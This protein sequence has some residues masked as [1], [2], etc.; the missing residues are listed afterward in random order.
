MTFQADPQHSGYVERGGPE[1]PLRLRWRAK[2]LPYIGYPVVGGGRV[3]VV[4]SEPGTYTERDDTLVRIRG[5]ARLVALSLRTGRRIWTRNIRP[6]GY[7]SGGTL[8]YDRGRVFVAREGGGMLAIAPDDGRVV[9]R[10]D[11][12]GGLTPPVAEGGVVYVDQPVGGNRG[13]S[14]WSQ[15]DG[16]MLWSVSF[17]WGTSGVFAVSEDHV[18]WG[19]TCAR[20]LARVNRTDG[21]LVEPFTT[22]CGLSGGMTMGTAL[23]GGNAFVYGVFG[24]ER[25][26]DAGTGKRLRRFRTLNTP[27]I[28]DGTLVSSVEALKS[29]P[30]SPPYTLDARTFSGRRLWRFAGDRYLDSPPLIV[31]DTVYVG[32]GSGRI[33]GVDLH[34]GRLRWQTKA[35]RAVLGKGSPQWTGLAAAE[36]VL[37]VPTF[38]SLLAYENAR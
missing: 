27:A 19:L 8:A 4:T 26:F 1:P 14:A 13:V 38:R 32:S 28:A 17:R 2:T 37:L 36:G 12:S 18:Y 3:F 5:R 11:V 16:S 34:S 9:R 29:V 31:G 10:F 30:D 6:S 23:G 15:A 24:E 21:S 25:I 7:Y 35:R 33:Y 20:E 22:E